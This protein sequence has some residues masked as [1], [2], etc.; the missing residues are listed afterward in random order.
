MVADRADTNARGAA[1]LPEVGELEVERD[2]E[3]HQRQHR[4]SAQLCLRVEVQLHRS[5]SASM[6]LSPVG[7]GASSRSWGGR[8]WR[9]AARLTRWA[10]VEFM[11]SG[12]RRYTGQRPLHLRRCCCPPAPISTSSS[13]AGE[14]RAAGGCAGRRGVDSAAVLAGSGLAPAALLDA[15]TRVRC[16]SCWR[17]TPTLHLAPEPASLRT[18][19]RT[20]I[21]HFGLYGYALPAPPH[22][23]R[24]TS[25]CATA[26]WPSPLIGW[27][28]SIA[29]GPAKRCGV[30]RSARPG[31][32]QRAASLRRRGCSWHTLLA[33]HC[34]LLGAALLPRRVRLRRRPR[35]PRCCANCSVAWWPSARAPTSWAS[36]PPRLD[37]PL[38]FA[39][40]VNAELARM[41]AAI[42]CWPRW[43]TR[44]HYRVRRRR[45][46]G[47]GG[48]AR[49]AALLL[50]SPVGFRIPPR[51]PSAWACTSAACASACARKTIV[52]GAA[53][54]AL[55]AGARLSARHAAQHRMTSPPRWASATQ[56]TS[57]TPSKRWT[58]E[59]R[60]RCGGAVT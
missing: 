21:T 13:T 33:V 37:H 32:R 6:G 34:D 30:R 40:P 7:T 11:E 46:G 10:P 48:A 3:H 41:A 31:A 60:A 8:F 20:R 36:T 25:R 24:S 51:W 56:R 43:S 2:A 42:G 50:A 55:H 29:T 22:A 4:G 23:G 39:S 49:V 17:C 9:G 27:P 38:A 45:R 14:D 44:T 53:A 26:P 54:S 19:L 52:P 58:G 18:G 1:R 47:R 15:A 57:A 5:M 28:S 59:S 16:A 12:Q 35:M